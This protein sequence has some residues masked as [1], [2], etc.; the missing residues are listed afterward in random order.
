MILKYL[1]EKLEFINVPLIIKSRNIK[2]IFFKKNDKTLRQTFKHKKYSYLNKLLSEKYTEYLN[3]NL[4]EFLN[5][6]KSKGDKNYKCFLNRYG[7]MKFC[8]FTIEQN[9]QDKGIYCFSINKSI[10]Y[11]GRCTDSFKKRINYGYGKIHPKNCFLDGQ[12]T[13]CHLNSL[14]NKSQN[15]QFM[16]YKMNDKSKKQIIEKEKQILT[17]NKYDWNLIC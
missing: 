7:D 12:R 17:F 9:L 16:I 3:H 6:L 2:N 8:E 4:G 11:I 5:L 14:I 13:N 10:K 15:V 1:D